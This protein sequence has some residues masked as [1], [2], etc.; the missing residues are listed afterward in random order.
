V[1][2]FRFQLAPSRVKSLG[3]EYL[4]IAHNFCVCACVGQLLP[5]WW[6]SALLFFSTT[7]SVSNLIRGLDVTEEKGEVQ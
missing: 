1:A 2:W 5:V 7:R 6:Y 3:E 4:M